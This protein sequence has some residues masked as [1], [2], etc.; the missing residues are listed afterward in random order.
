MKK[1]EQGISSFLPQN[2]QQDEETHKRI[3]IT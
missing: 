2:D 3:N 1:M